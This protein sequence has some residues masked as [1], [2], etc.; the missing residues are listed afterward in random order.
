MYIEVTDHVIYFDLC[1]AIGSMMRMLSKY[2]R[3]VLGQY[4]FTQSHEVMYFSVAKFYPHSMLLHHYYYIIKKV[5]TYDPLCPPLPPSSH[6]GVAVW[7]RS[8][9][10]SCEGRPLP[11]N[12]LPV[13][14]GMRH[15]VVGYTCI[16]AV[17]KV[18]TCSHH[19]YYGNLM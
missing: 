19:D 10:S 8:W 15:Q 14:I 16:D 4:F 6:G 17:L 7:S 9:R 12:C 3:A 2:T 1:L 5:L 18:M 11:I 13:E